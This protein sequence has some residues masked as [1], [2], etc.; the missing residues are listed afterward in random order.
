MRQNWLL[1][2]RSRVSCLRSHA[3]TSIMRCGLCK[4]LTLSYFLAIKSLN[5]WLNSRRREKYKKGGNVTPLRRL[6]IES[7]RVL[8]LSL[9]TVF[10]KDVIGSIFLGGEISA[11]H[12]PCFKCGW[13]FWPMAWRDWNH[14]NGAEFKLHGLLIIYLET[15]SSC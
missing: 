3:V 15:F 5:N 9:T 14:A 7:S 4:P 8:H 2:K 1:T 10:R 13:G 6:L 12:R 11:N